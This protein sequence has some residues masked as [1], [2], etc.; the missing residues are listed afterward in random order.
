[1]QKRTK[2]NSFTTAICKLPLTVHSKQRFKKVMNSM[3][4]N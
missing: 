4:V 3:L 2:E 1:M